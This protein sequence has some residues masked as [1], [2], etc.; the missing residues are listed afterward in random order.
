MEWA[1][2]VGRG[3]ATLS[4]ALLLTACASAATTSALHDQARADYKSCLETNAAQLDNGTQDTI[5]VAYAVKAACSTAFLALKKTYADN[6]PG[7][8][9]ALFMAEDT[10]PQQLDAALSV[11]SSRRTAVGRAPRS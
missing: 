9:G 4:F 7:G 1:P 10:N 8:Y 11:V 6:M 2:R 5:T 3:C